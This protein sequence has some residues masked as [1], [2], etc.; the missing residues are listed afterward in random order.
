RPFLRRGGPERL[1]V[2]TGRIVSERANSNLHARELRLL[3]Q[4]LDHRILKRGNLCRDIGRRPAH[5]IPGTLSLYW[6]RMALTSGTANSAPRIPGVTT[7]VRLPNSSAYLVARSSMLDRSA[8]SRSTRS[9][10]RVIS[11]GTRS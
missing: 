3:P 4:Q 7:N 9:A 10:A 11:C 5:A 2:L 1:D 8:T 6:F